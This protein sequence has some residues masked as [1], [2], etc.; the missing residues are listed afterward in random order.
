MLL[1]SAAYTFGHYTQNLKLYTAAFPHSR[2]V[3]AVLERERERE[4][5]REIERERER[6][7]WRE[8]QIQEQLHSISSFFISL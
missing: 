7:R 3:C 6:E 2:T 1:L 5:E 4:K 8:R